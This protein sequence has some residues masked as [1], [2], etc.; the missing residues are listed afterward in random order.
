MRQLF[1]RRPDEAAGDDLVV[2]AVRAPAEG[3][4]RKVPCGMGGAKQRD[5]EVVVRTRLD[6]LDAI[7][8]R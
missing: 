4:L 6:S 8:A 7:L 2:A 1:A 5:H 3:Q